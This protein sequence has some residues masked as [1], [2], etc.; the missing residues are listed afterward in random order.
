MT[1]LVHQPLEGV[2]ELEI[3]K[4]GWKPLTSRFE[5][6][7]GES[8][9]PETFKLQQNDGPVAIAADPADSLVVV[10]GVFRGQAPLTLFLSPEKEH[11]IRFS[12]QGYTEVVRTVRSVS[13][14]TIPLS[15]R[16]QPQYGTLFLTTSPAGAMLR[17]NGR[18]SGGASQRLNLQTLPQNLEISLSGYETYRTTITPRAGISSQLEVTLRT[19]ADEAKEEAQRGVYSP[20]RQKLSLIYLDKPA[21]F[22]IGSSRREAARRSNEF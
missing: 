21:R 8:L 7:A 9:T 18:D 6:K 3:A 4:E 13:G 5:I 19:A 2:Y 16:L 15:V 17:I 20:G 22:T 14:K 11:E 10:N 1:P 12:K